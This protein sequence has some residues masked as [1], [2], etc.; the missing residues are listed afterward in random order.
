MKISS[1]VKLLSVLGFLFLSAP[2]MAL[3]LQVPWSD[4]FGA[5]SNLRPIKLTL[6]TSAISTLV[7]ILCGVPLAWVIANSSERVANLLRPIILAPLVLPPAVA[8]IALFALFG[9][10]GI[11]GKQLFTIFDIS[12][13]FTSAAVVLVGIFIGLP[14]LI[15][16]CESQFR[17]MPKDQHDAATLDRA[18]NNQYF[19]R[20]VLPQSQGAIASGAVL[21]WA[22]IIGEFGATLMFAGS[23]PGSTQTV[24]LYIYQAMEI[25][26][27]AAYALSALMIV[28]AVS[29]LFIFR[30]PFQNAM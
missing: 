25:N 4:F 26:P 18:T 20:V 6:W 12:I 30:K 1:S 3:F 19:K 22:R 14:Y 27:S 2:V 11:L 5:I 28:I 24:S 7:T 29:V 10:N 16:I 17:Q 23:L 15:L 8:G 21:S 9:R 13:P